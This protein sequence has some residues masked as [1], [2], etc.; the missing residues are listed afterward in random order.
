MTT[1]QYPIH[2]YLFHD[3][4]DIVEPYAEYLN[5]KGFRATAFSRPSL[6]LDRVKQGLGEADVILLHNDLG[7]FVPE[8]DKLGI[9]AKRIIEE[10]HEE[11]PHLRIGIVSGGWPNGEQDV[12]RMGADFYCNALGLTDNWVL[13]QLSQGYASQ[14]QQLRRGTNL[15]VQP[16][17]R[18]GIER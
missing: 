18:R 3:C 7:H 2:V 13:N 11:A 8:E 4:K 15:E 17:Y 10:I 12:R 16:L 1:S 6:I 14:E 5:E 9:T